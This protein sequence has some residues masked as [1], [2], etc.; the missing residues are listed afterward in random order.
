[1]ISRFKTLSVNQF[2]FITALFYVAI[3]NLPLF[4]IVRKGIEKQPEVDPL[5]IASMP[6]FLTFAL[7]FLF[8][9]FTVKYLLKPFFIVLTLLSSSVFFA[10][11][12]YNV[13][14]DY[15]MIE[16]TFQTHPAEALMYVNL[17]S[18]TNLLLTGLLP[19]YLIYKADIHYQPFIK[20]L[21]H[22]LAFMGSS[23]KTGKI[24]R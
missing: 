18:I 4:G 12:Q 15:G 21:L 2:T 11:Y 16:N 13:V 22:K 10:A 1:M 7:S 23:Q 14:F 3:F 20:E 6:L 9:I 19:S 8:S 24:A 17:A 5:F